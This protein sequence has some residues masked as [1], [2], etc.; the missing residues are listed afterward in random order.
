MIYS[1]SSQR[2]DHKGAD[3]TNT[4]RFYK[5]GGKRAEPWKA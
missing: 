4:E 2:N 3:W 1:K 5:K